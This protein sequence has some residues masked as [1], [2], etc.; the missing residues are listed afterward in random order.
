MEYD[1]GIRK[2]LNME[3]PDLTPPEKILQNICEKISKETEN[4]ISGIV[5]E[6]DGPIRSYRQ[7][8]ISETVTQFNKPK[9]V[10]VQDTLGELGNEHRK[11]EFCITT[12]IYEHFRYRLMFIEYDLAVYP[13]TVVLEEQI[14]RELQGKQEQSYIFTCNTREDFETFAIN[15]VRT[16]C[17]SQMMQRLINVGYGQQEQ[18]NSQLTS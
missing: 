3:K 15:I 17:V 7:A 8:P 10:N 9:E 5:K 11:F 2:R 12:P 13:V 4:A 1:L 16:E 6:F 14:A 18:A